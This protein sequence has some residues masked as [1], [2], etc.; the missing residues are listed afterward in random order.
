MVNWC[1]ALGT[2]LANDE[3]V[4]GFSV[5][6]GHP[7]S[8]IMKQWSLR[9]TAYADRLLEGLESIDWPENIKKFSATGLT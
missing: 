3:V 5:R 8:E 9:I 2:V 4:E 1:S 6:G 7:V